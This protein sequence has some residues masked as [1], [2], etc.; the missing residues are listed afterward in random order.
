MSPAD[1]DRSGH[2]II[3]STPTPCV[4]ASAET[5]GQHALQVPPTVD[6]LPLPSSSNASPD[7]SIPPPAIPPTI[8][9]PSRPIPRSSPA[10]VR[11]IQAIAKLTRQK[12]FDPTLRGRLA[13]MLAFLRFYA[14]EELQLTWTAASDLAAKGAG[15]GP[16]LGRRLR[17]WTQDFLGDETCLLKLRYFRIREAMVE[18]EEVAQEIQLHLQ[19]L[20]R[21][22][23]A[24]DVVAY[25]G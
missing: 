6:P 9:T 17:V 20:G 10:L 13:T 3:P 15:R 2:E 8:A 11:A 1:Q 25:S 24:A 16:W 19:S 22:F 4:A 21:W 7:L 14:A 18:N 12:D 5:A 23:S